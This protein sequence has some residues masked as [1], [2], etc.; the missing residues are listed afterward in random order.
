[1]ENSYNILIKLFDKYEL[2]EVERLE[3][4]EIIKRYI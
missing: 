3:I 4:Y 2:H 1:M